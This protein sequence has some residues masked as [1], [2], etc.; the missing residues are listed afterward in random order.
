MEKKL[1][2]V[3]SPAKANTIEKYLGKE[4]RVMSSVG[5]IRDLATTGP[6]GL[7]VDVENEFTPNYRTI[8]GKGKVLKELRKAVK[9]ADAV[10]LATDPDREGEAISWHL[11]DS[12]KLGEKETMKVYRVVFHEITKSVILKAINNPREINYD[13]VRSQESR[14]ILDRIIGFKLSKLLQTKIGSKSAG[15]V[16]SVALK[17]IVDRER[18]IEAFIPEE[19]WTIEGLFNKNNI[20]FDGYLIKKGNDKISISNEDEAN[21]ILNDLTDSY[22]IEGIEKNVKNKYPKPPF[23]TSTLQQEA[24]TK[25]YFNSR[26][27][28]SVAQKLYEGIEVNG[29]PLG[30]ITYMRTDSV[31]LSD[32]FVS[33]AKMYI[34]NNFGKDYLGTGSKKEKKS[35]NAQDA[36][37]GIRPTDVTMT[38]E[39]MKKFLTKEQYKLYKL[40]WS[41]A[42]A[43]MMHPA[44]VFHTV[45]NIQ[46]NDY[47]FKG[48]GQT[49]KFDGY[50]K[51]YGDYEQTK[52]TILPDL[53]KG[54][55]VN[56]KKIEKIQHFTQPKARY[57]EAKLIKEME[58]LG[59]GRPSTYSATMETLRNRHYVTVEQK[60][61]HPTEQG[62]ITID[63]LVEF[64]TNIINVTYTAEMEETLDQI[65]KGDKVWHKE[66][67]TFYDLFIPLVDYAKENMEKIP[68][69]ET[70]ENCPECGEPLVFR[71]S[72]YGEFVGCSG[73]PECKYIKKE[74]EEEPVKTDVTCPKCEEGVFVERVAKR[75]RNKGNKFFACSNYPKCKNAVSNQPTHEVCTDC[76]NILT[77][78][79]GEVICEN[80]KCVRNKK[81]TTKEETTTKKT[82]TNKGTAK[83][84]ST[85]KKTTTKATKK[86]TTT[87]KKV[88]ENKV[89]DEVETK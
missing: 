15:R 60:K 44:Q 17:L 22:I 1:V 8:R 62:I 33:A 71:Q 50:L 30:L 40:I 58:E 4:F 46:N 59:I 24:S 65:A 69:R 53:N 35:K 87:K 38:P 32:E 19:Y 64:F 26:K 7:G 42:V 56:D 52:V 23:I 25:L 6:G 78:K 29:S 68:P 51:V 3:E 76:G 79:D 88:T 67:K 72:R 74:D 89:K 41:R 55:K 77:E 86:K 75:G 2:I 16:Q 83:K 47:V 12:L 9:E 84:T 10:Y 85:K 80:K 21:A 49:M 31:R 37:E 28:M 43:S 5:H 82:S 54:E 48:T 18:E 27:T 57:S 39:S 81:E 63:K 36:H 20:D 11:Y 13:L 73:Y 14:R 45:L 70:G 34:S 66:L 61:F